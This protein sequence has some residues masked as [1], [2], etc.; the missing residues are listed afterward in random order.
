MKLEA[1]I[2][3]VILLK[4]GRIASET[5]TINLVKKIAI[6]KYRGSQLPGTLNFCVVG[7]KVIWLLGFICWLMRTTNT[8]AISHPAKP[9]Q[10][11][12]NADK[13]PAKDKLIMT[14]GNIAMRRLGS[15]RL[16]DC[17]IP[18]YIK[19]NNRPHTQTGVRV[20]I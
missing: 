16:L 9:I 10:F 18:K 12:P 15:S 5:D 19:S 4:S 6:I 13:I 11:A 17:R 1:K 2:N 20:I 3:A 8:K 14:M 7:E